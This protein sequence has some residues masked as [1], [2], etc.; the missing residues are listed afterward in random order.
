MEDNEISSEDG[1]Q[2]CPIVERGLRRLGDI[3]AI[4]C[5]ECE[6]RSWGFEREIHTII[7][8]Y[9]KHAGDLPENDQIIKETTRYRRV[10]ANCGYKGVWQYGLRWNV[11]RNQGEPVDA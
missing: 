11:K 7:R 9:A 10:C 4:P 5:P 2:D 6:L 1:P 8:G 3:R